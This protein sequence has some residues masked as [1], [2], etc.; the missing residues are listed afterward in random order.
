MV[1]MDEGRDRWFG[2]NVLDGLV[3]N[4][5]ELNFSNGVGS[6]GGKLSEKIRKWD[7]PDKLPFSY[8][9]GIVLGY[10]VEMGAL[11]YCAREAWN[12]NFIPLGVNAGVKSIFRGLNLLVDSV[13]L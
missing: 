12:G 10:A 7:D 3:Q 13:R 11:Y 2:R 8:N 6:W 1:W 5:L 9:A 4:E